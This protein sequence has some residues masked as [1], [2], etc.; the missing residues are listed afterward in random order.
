MPTGT[1][2]LPRAHRADFRSISLQENPAQRIVTGETCSIWTIL[3]TILS[4][5][6]RQNVHLLLIRPPR[7]VSLQSVLPVPNASVTI[8]DK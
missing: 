2:R 6:P 4:S 3:W 1:P 5:P 8:T 7:T